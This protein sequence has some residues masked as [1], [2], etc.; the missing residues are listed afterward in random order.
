ME[1]QLK[2]MDH[3]ANVAIDMAIRFGPKLL[4]AVLILAAG[5][6]AGRWAGRA[7]RRALAKLRL[8]PRCS[9]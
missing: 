4:V 2:F 6:V 8:D 9:P 1:E 3:V 7:L 5:F